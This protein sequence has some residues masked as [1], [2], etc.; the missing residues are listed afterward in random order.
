[1]SCFWL[2][3]KAAFLFYDSCKA[4]SAFISMYCGKVRFSQRLFKNLPGSQHI[5]DP[6]A[7]RKRTIGFNS[8]VFRWKPVFKTSKFMGTYSWKAKRKQMFSENY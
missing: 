3:A 5:K 4:Y 1:M 6:V 8:A 7:I 2:I